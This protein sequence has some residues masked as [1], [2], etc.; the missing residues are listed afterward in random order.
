M[1]YIIDYEK[2]K[3]SN[4][5]EL[6]NT[7][8]CLEKELEDSHNTISQQEK[9]ISDLWKEKNDLEARFRREQFSHKMTVAEVE[10]YRQQLLDERLHSDAER[11]NKKFYIDSL[12]NKIQVKRYSPPYQI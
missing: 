9:I 8:R 5:A 6:I 1:S 11:N 4:K 7:I 2:V 12:G 10:E 3:K